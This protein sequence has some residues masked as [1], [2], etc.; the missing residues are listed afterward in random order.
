MDIGLL[1]HQYKLLIN[2]VF[3]LITLC[4]KTFIFLLTKER[5]H[6]KLDHIKYEVL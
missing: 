6:T 5:F 1:L 4:I 2:S 3:K